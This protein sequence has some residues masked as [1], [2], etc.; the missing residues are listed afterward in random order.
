G[1]T[2]IPHGDD[3]LTE[4]DVAYF[5]TTPKYVQHIREVAGKENYP[6]VKHIIVMGGGHTAVQTLWNLPDNMHAKVIESD[7]RRCER[8]NEL[9]DKRNVLV[10]HGDGRDQEL[11]A[12]EG[13]D[14][15]EAFVALTENSETNILACMA[16]K[17]FGVRKTVAM[18]ENT[19]YISMAESFDIGSI[20]NKKT[21]AA[22]HIYQMMLKADIETMKSLTV[23]NADVA[24]FVVKEGARLTRKPVK[25]LKLPATLTLGGLVRDGRGYL[26]NG[27]TQI[28]SGDTVVAF[29]LEN[30]VKQ[31][32]KFLR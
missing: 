10:L 5:M 2:L 23:A 4:G 11:L 3:A 32:E 29:C 25:D 31:L 20:I 18:I 8:L 12:E 7:V 19:D 24:E 30:A 6:D 15:A 1:D 27:M 22:S 9:L 14:N 21:F 17:R 13:I 26:I 28:Q 16:A